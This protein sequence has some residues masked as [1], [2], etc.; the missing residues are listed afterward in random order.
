MLAEQF[1]LAVVPGIYFSSF[2][3]RWIRFSYAL[4]PEVTGAATERL[5]EA[6]SSL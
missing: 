6:L 2:G 3:S 4:P 1:G 5:R